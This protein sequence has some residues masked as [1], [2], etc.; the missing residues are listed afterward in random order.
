[1]NSRD[2]RESLDGFELLIRESLQER[3]GGCAP[4]PDVRQQLLGRAARQQ[5]R[6]IW[7]L[8]AVMRSRMDEGSPR[9]TYQFSPNHRFYFEALFAGRLGWMALNQL[10]R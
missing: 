2:R 9:P 8:P 3:T 5:R 7:R 1:M 10:V 4:A 6:F